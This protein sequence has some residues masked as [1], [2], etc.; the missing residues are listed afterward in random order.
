M[1]LTTQERDL[2]LDLLLKEVNHVDNENATIQG[3][4]KEYRTLVLNIY[5]KIV[6]TMGDD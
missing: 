1:E 3:M 4:L 6:D 5:S 2:L